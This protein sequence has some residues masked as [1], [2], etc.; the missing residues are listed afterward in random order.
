MSTEA[1]I[2]L[3]GGCSSVARIC[4][5]HKTTVFRWKSGK[6]PMPETARRLLALVG[7]AKQ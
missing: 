5:V 2:K 7:I 1:K 4:G 3:H 6:S